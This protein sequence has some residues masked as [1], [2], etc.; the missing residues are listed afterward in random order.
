MSHSG[1]GDAGRKQQAGPGSVLKGPWHSAPRKQG[2]GPRPSPLPSL[3]QSR[4]LLTSCPF[5]SDTRKGEAST[6]LPQ[7]CLR[8]WTVP[9]LGQTHLCTRPL[10]PC[11]PS[12]PTL[13][14]G[15]G[16]GGSLPA[17]PGFA[18]GLPDSSSTPTGRLSDAARTPQPG[19]RGHVSGQGLGALGR[20]SHGGWMN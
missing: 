9:A 4:L 19:P 10:T 17:A 12:C 2:R 14:R 15:A 5:S 8:D 6:G 20:A 11:L 13:R 3:K 7:S 16:C 18:V 1:F